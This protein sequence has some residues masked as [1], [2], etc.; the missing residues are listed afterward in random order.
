MKKLLLI[1]IVLLILLSACSKLEVKIINNSARDLSNVKI[2]Y[3][4]K[5]KTIASVP[6]GR[7]SISTISPK[8]ESSMKIEFQANGETH[9]QLC[10]VYIF[11]GAEGLITITI[12]DKFAITCDSEIS[13][14]NVSR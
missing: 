14:I 5:T 7:S 13:T 1:P 3:S 8:A 9:S 10:D 11:R 12:D 2:I 6:H 4:T